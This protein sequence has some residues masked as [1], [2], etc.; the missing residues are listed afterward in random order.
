MLVCIMCSGFLHLVEG[1]SRNVSTSPFPNKKPAIPFHNIQI[2]NSLNFVT[3]GD[4]SFIIK[5]K[6]N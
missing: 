5:T 1:I 4:V 2:C 6:V 3:G